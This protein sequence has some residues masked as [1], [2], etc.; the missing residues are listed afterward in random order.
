LNTAKTRL[1]ATR[2]LK[3]EDDPA[4]E[5]GQAAERND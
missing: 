2:I 5:P 3:F 1:P 4:D